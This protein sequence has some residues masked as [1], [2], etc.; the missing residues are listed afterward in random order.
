M[1]HTVLWPA[2]KA[3]CASVS[4]S[5]SD[6]AIASTPWDLMQLLYESDFHFPS[7]C[8]KNSLPPPSPP[9]G[10]TC[11]QYAR[12]AARTQPLVIPPTSPLHEG[13]RLP[14]PAFNLASYHA[15]YLTPPAARWREET[16]T[17]TAIRSSTRLPR[18]VP[19]RERL[20]R[21]STCHN[22]SAPQLTP[23]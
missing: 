2:C 22:H 7:L 1:S 15:W 11:S 8:K 21:A 10:R 18:P 19:K 14:T 13:K 16:Y 17:K 6:T 3:G 12:S 20:T 23:F 9:T 4:A 5:M